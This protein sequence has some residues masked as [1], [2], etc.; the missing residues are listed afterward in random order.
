MV[1][2]VSNAIGASNFAF[3]KSLD[4]IFSVVSCKPAK[5]PNEGDDGEEQAKYSCSKLES[6]E[7]C[8]LHEQEE[9]NSMNYFTGTN[10]NKITK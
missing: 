7:V 4:S 5:W 8:S 10:K 1:A 9:I 2:A 3:R 6:N